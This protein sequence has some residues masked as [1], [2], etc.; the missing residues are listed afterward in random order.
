MSGKKITWNENNLTKN[1]KYFHENPPSKIDEPKTPYHPKKPR[2]D[3]C[4]SMS[5]E[6]E[7]LPCKHKRYC[8][9][10][11]ISLA[12]GGR[13]SRCKEFFVDLNLL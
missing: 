3:K 13:C 7:I 6:Y 5:V 10:C 8:R 11:A 2:C 12:T 1:R 4:G 9:K